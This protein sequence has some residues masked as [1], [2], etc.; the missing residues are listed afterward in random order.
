MLFLM[1]SMGAEVL[2]GPPRGAQDERRRHCH[3][4]AILGPVLA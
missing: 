2:R 4:A 1:I 3:V